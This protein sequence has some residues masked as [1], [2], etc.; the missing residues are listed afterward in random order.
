[1]KDGGFICQ[2]NRSGA[3]HSSLHSTTSLAEGIQEYLRNGYSYRAE[4]LHEAEL[5]CREFILQHRLYLSDRTG[6]IIRKEF[7]QLPYPW[8]WKFNILRGLEYFRNAGVNYDERMAPAIEVLVSKR[9]KDNRWNLNAKHAGQTHFD[10]EKPGSP[11]RWNTLN[12]LRVLKHFN[13][14]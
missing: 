11:S 1:M 12:A 2:L 3:N 14:E 8:R 5:N 6:K 10:M 7:L 9:R 4:E 13:I